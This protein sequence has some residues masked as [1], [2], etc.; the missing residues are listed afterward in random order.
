MKSDE[1]NAL[2]ERKERS[3]L[4][5]EEWLEF[6]KT[7]WQ[8]PNVRDDLHPA[9][10][11]AEIPRR[12][13][14]M[15][16]LVEDVV[17]DPFCGVGTTG[18]VAAGLER[19]S[20]CIDQ[21]PSYVKDLACRAKAIPNDLLSFRVGDAR[22]LVGIEEDSIQLIVTSPPYWDKAHYGGG[23]N[24]LGVTMPYRDFLTQMRQAFKECYRVLAP[25]RKLCVVTANVN[26]A[27]K[28]GLL[29]FP[30]AADY[31]QILRKIGFL[32]VSE[33]IWNKNGTGGRW[34]S[35]NGRR[36]IFGSYPYPPNF[37]FKNVHEY[38][39]IM[40]KP[41]ASGTDPEGMGALR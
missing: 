26:L 12:L 2:K 11:P 5:K 22:R 39:L 21:N 7:V 18:I 16:S 1:Q 28:E 23:V 38:I 13:I 33:I 3:K 29:T 20:I 17:L 37:L 19:R 34:G 14:K 36:P 8:I 4:T 6:T 31:L 24:D 25:S 41:R 40:R 9:V 10:F 35:A 27:S 30:I 32:T 15:F